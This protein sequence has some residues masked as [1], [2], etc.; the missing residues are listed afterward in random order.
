MTE[1][2]RIRWCDDPESSTV[3]STGY[4]GTDMLHAFTV[5]T[6]DLPS[7]E[8]TLTSNLP[9]QESER[10]YGTIAEV[11]LDAEG[12]FVQFVTSLDATFPKPQAVYAP[13]GWAAR[14]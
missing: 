12:L 14:R 1:T 9:G 3:A 7:G 11:K 2:P 10:S 5:L 13:A 4:V 8:H 6:P